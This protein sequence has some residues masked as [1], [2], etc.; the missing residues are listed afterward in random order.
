MGTASL[1]PRFADHQKFVAL[2]RERPAWRPGQREFS[3]EI[4]G[5]AGASTDSLRAGD[6]VGSVAA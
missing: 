2:H 3:M 1:A 4:S 6:A 5:S